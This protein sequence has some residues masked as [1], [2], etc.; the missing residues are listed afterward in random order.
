M[1]PC[2]PDMLAAMERVVAAVGDMAALS[3]RVFARFLA[4]Y[5]DEAARFINLDAAV[6]RMTDETLVLL[7]GLAGG[8]GWAAGGA[9]HWADLHRN[10]GAIADDRYRA[11]TQLVVEELALATEAEW[12]PSASGWADA[13]EQLTALLL[14]ANQG[15]SQPASH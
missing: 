2:H 13:S 4:E 5:P 9:A 12:L 8:E 14:A 11:W 15:T 3:Q 10:Y 1:A 6:L 7:L